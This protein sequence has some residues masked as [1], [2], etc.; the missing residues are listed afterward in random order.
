MRTLALGF[1][2]ANMHVGVT[3]RCVP[4]AVSPCVCPSG[5]CV[6]MC[7]CPGLE[8]APRGDE[9][10]CWLKVSWFRYHACTELNTEGAQVTRRVRQ[11]QQQLYPL[12]PYVIAHLASRHSLGNG[13]PPRCEDAVIINLGCRP[14]LS[15][16]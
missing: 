14:A 16:L 5:V 3:A 4:A 7:M 9:R 10:S 15:A 8:D 13:H 2:G 6:I 11:M 1:T 12:Q